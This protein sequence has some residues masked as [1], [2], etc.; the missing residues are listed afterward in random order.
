MIQSHLKMLP[1]IWKDV[2]NPE[3]YI[4]KYTSNLSTIVT[5][6]IF[7]SIGNPYSI[8][9]Q[10]NDLHNQF[11]LNYEVADPIIK[12]MNYNLEEV[13]D[14]I[15]NDLLTKYFCHLLKLEYEVMDRDNP[16][17]LYH[18]LNKSS[19]FDM[20]GKPWQYDTENNKIKYANNISLHYRE[21]PYIGAS[22]TIEDDITNDNLNTLVV[23]YISELARNNIQPN[24]LL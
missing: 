10:L 22:I 6:K 20:Y 11:T 4:Y 16:E 9:F 15:Q 2:T 19:I 12:Q 1:N 14:K 24:L 5:F 18:V 13:I 23:L 8:V 21:K 7:K 3:M 17:K